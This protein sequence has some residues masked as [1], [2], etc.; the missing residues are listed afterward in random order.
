MDKALLLASAV[1]DVKKQL[2][3]LQTKA[4]EIQKLEGPSGPKGDKGD[5]GPKGDRGER[6]L[7]GK[8]GKDGKDGKDGVDG[9][10]GKDGISVVDAK[11][12]FDGSLVLSLSDG[13]EVDAGKVVSGS[14]EAIYSTVKQGAY[15][16]N[17]LLP[18]QEGQSGNVLTTDGTNTYWV[19]AGGGST[20]SSLTTADIGVTVQAYTANLVVDG[21]YVHTDNNYTTAEKSKLS[22]IAAGAEVNVNA[23]WSAVAGDAL[24]LN[25]PTIPT[26]TSALTNDSGFITSYT[27]TDPV[28]TASTWY[29]T[30]NNSSNWNTA[31]GW[32]NHA[33]AGYLTSAAIGVSVQA[34]LTSGTNIKTINGT[35]LLG[36]GDVSI[37][38]GAI[39][40]AEALLGADVQLTTSNTW[41]DGPSVSLA[42][43]TWLV[44]GHITFWRTATTATTWFGRITDGTNHHA[45]SQM[46][47]ASLAGIGGNVSLNAVIVLTGTTTIKL[48][49]TTNAGATACLMKAATTANGSGNNATIITAIKLA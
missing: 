17:E 28:Y 22:G 49:G 35:T 25:K 42:A 21:S 44:T 7:D 5:Q 24:I 10:S 1:A 18:P 11:V 27:E 38:S 3:E 40:N 6:G 4:T 32:G 37:T 45:S 46:Y 8:A 34:K 31:Y 26:T 39:T 36:S 33:S 30:T 19:A 2:A 43:G 9:E 23:D 41:Y 16:L 13:K 14:G 15:S 12:D 29:S 48:Q 20:G 47:T